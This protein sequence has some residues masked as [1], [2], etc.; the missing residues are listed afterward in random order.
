MSFAGSGYEDDFV[1]MAPSVRTFQEPL[2]ISESLSIKYN[3]LFNAIITMCMKIG[4]NFREPRVDV[5][6]H[7]TALVWNDK[8]KHL[9]NILTHD[10]SDS[11]D[12]TLKMAF[13]YLMSINWMWNSTKCQA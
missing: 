12:V 6:L 11:T 1:I 13:L 8:V 9:G 7:G 2:Y 10:L 3:V 4:N 5:T